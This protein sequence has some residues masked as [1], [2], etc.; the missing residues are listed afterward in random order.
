MKSEE[1]FLLVCTCENENLII[2]EEK[3]IY[4]QFYPQIV[5]G[6]TTIGQQTLESRGLNFHGYF[7][8]ISVGA[9]M[10]LALLF[11]IGFTLALTFLKR[12]FIF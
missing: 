5:S 8:W 6:N 3:A 10:G 12:K 7:Y 1:C 11:N 2:L 9:L 4:F